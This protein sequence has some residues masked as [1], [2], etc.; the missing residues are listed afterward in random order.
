MPA[1][2]AVATTWPTSCTPAPT[3]WPNPVAE[4][5]S[6]CHSAGS[7]AIA[8]VPH[9]VTSATGTACSSSFARTV[10]A[11]APIAEA[12]QIANPLATSTGWCPG[13]PSAR[14]RPIVPTNVSTTTATVVTI[15]TQP[16][17]AM[18]TRLSFRPSSTMPMRSSRRDGDRSPGAS[19]ARERGLQG[20]HLADDDAERDGRR[21]D[22]HGGQREVREPRDEG[23]GCRDGES[24]HPCAHHA[25]PARRPGNGQVAQLGG[26]K[27]SCRNSGVTGTPVQIG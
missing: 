4:R 27:C 7:T 13:R 15:V 9:S 1:S 2:C 20:G 23:R 10:A 16:S 11:I 17:P 19:A 21:E 12:P 18:S 25:T 5:P 6:G 22:R 24:R 8:S 3:Q 14:P 26:Q